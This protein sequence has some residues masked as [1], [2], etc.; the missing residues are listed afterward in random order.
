MLVF[1]AVRA[2]AFNL[3]PELLSACGFVGSHMSGMRHSRA[4]AWLEASRHDRGRA[5]TVQPVI[6][7]C[8]CEAPA[9]KSCGFALLVWSPGRLASTSLWPSH[10]YVTGYV[11]MRI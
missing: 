3:H 11:A 4:A 6:D 5:A 9:G 1:C 2:A 8:A 7:M 10:G